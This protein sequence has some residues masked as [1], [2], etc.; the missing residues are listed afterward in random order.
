MADVLNALERRI[1]PSLQA[2]DRTAGDD[3]PRLRILMPSYRSNPHTGGQGVYLRHISRALTDL[4]HQVDV[5]S[6]P[7]YP[8][9]DP[10]VR[11]L[12]LPSLDLYARPRDFLGVPRPPLREMKH[13]IDAV[14][15]LLH[16][17]GGFGEPYT[18]G[19]RLAREFLPRLGDYDVV[20]DNQTLCYGLLKL[21]AGGIPVV[22]TIH[23]PI[24]R[25]RDIAVAHAED[26]GFRLLIR[27]WY[28]FLRMQ[29]AVARALDPVIVVSKSTMRDVIADFG[30]DP[31]HLALVYHGIDHETFRPLPGVA[32]KPR[33]LITT[34]SADV[35]IKG[36]IYLMRAFAE[37]AVRYEDLELVIVGQ[38]REGPSERLVRSLGLGSRIHFATGISD[39]ALVR[40]YA[41]ASIA[42]CPSLYEGF[43]FP[44]GEAMACEVPVVATRGGSL[45]EVV[46]DAGVLVEPGDVGALAAGI[47]SLID[48]PERAGRLGPAG[49]ARIVA[50]YDWQRTAA[51]VVEVYRKAIA[52]AHRQAR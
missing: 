42:V 2:R 5:V 8:E 25:D 27:R 19:E 40:H 21:A 51:G 28:S 39:E 41:E 49:R 26:F 23:H 17:S 35:P 1:E 52:H 44:P 13:A 48:D 33:R 15:Y 45:P 37:L 11:L 22:G 7:P 18:F 32:R 43:G 4:G 20:H 30:L 50:L 36:L 29:K 16:I 38:L 46:G 9:L 10:R 12:K 34:T 6:G 24:T 31:A 3:A 47:A 14:E